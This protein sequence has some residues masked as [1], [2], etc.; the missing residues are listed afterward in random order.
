MSTSNYSIAPY[1]LRPAAAKPGA[2]ERPPWVQ[3]GLLHDLLAVL[4]RQWRVIVATV[5]VIVSATMI[6]SLLA[7][8]VYS[9]R[10]T[11]L[12]EARS[13]QVMSSPPLRRGRRSLR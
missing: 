10:A 12:I 2:T 5:A 9:A 3:G 4:E 11:V 13:P 7:E 8:P 6:Y 1:L